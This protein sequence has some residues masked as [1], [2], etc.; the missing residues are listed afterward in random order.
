MG[1]GLN[2]DGRLEVFARG[3]DNRIYD[4]WQKTPGEGLWNGFTQLGS[5]DVFASGPSVVRKPDGHLHVFVRG[6]QNDLWHIFQQ[7]LNGGWSDWESLGGKL[8]GT[9]VPAI[10]EDGMRII[11][12]STGSNGK[13]WY[14]EQKTGG[15]GWTESTEHLGGELVGSPVAC[16]NA[17]GRLVVFAAFDDNQLRFRAQDVTNFNSWDNDWTSLT[18]PVTATPAAILNLDL[19]MQII[20]PGVGGELGSSEQATAGDVLDWNSV[21]FDGIAVG[22]P[23]ISR[24][25]H[26]LPDAD[27]RLEAFHIGL[28]GELYHKWQ[29][30][31]DGGW[32]GWVSLGLSNLQPGLCVDRNRDLRLEVFAI[33]NNGNVQHA[34]Q[35]LPGKDPWISGN[36]GGASLGGLGT[37]LEELGFRGAWW[38]R[39]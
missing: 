31:P 32:S 35:T 37:K 4:N 36:L 7:E 19:S 6:L 27:G 10:R 2:A 29:T 22:A 25:G 13:L 23:V 38:F 9:P 8:A 5:I 33:D 14:I 30:A 16:S 11:V 1:T 26:V 3:S 34:W 17:D 28:T 20:I 24:N 21:P 15:S 12:F 39:E 18:G